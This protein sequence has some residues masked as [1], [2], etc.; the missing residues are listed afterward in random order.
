LLFTLNYLYACTIVHTQLRIRLSVIG[1]C[2]CACTKSPP[3]IRLHRHIPTLSPN[4]LVHPTLPC[5]SLTLLIDVLFTNVHSNIYYVLL[6]NT[7]LCTAYKWLMLL[8]V[9]S[10]YICS[11]ISGMIRCTTVSSD[12]NWVAVGFSTGWISTLDLRTG[13]LLSSHKAHETDVLEVRLHF[14]NLNL[15]K[16]KS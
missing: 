16:L 8:L 3:S 12:S 7:V 11:H 14:T 13:G 10:I 1:E 6:I 2:T 9:D 15:N 4:S 5:P